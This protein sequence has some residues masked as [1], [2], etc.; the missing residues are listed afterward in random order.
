MV[1]WYLSLLE[2][3]AGRWQRALDHATAAHELAEQ[4]QHPT[5]PACGG[6]RQGARRGRSRPRRRGTRLGRGGT[7]LLEGTSNESL[8]CPHARCARPARAGAGQPGDRRRLP[9]RA[10]RTAARRRAERPDAASVGRHDRDADRAR[11]ARAGP[12]LPRAVRAERAASR[13]PAGAGRRRTAAAACSPRRRG[14]LAPR[15]RHSSGARRACRRRRGRSSAA[16]RCSA[17]GTVRRQAQ[18]KKA[19][20]EALE[21]ALAIFEELGARLWAE[22]ARGRAERGSAAAP[23]LRGADRDRTPGRRARRPAVA[24]TSRSPPSCTWA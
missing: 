3:L 23:R 12:R 2:W 19:A 13:E 14:S 16:A 21:Q 11:R 8:R 24:R 7:R 4:T 9:A 5:Q 18:Q 17:C 1:C 10:A 6:A 15:S 22:K 20:R